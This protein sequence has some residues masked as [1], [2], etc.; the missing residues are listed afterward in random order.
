MGILTLLP[1]FL[2]NLHFEKGGFYRDC[3][4][5]AAAAARFYAADAG[6]TT[7]VMPGSDGMETI[8]ILYSL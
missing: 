6:M 5:S 3:Y 1:T 2:K 8:D 7:G 4:E